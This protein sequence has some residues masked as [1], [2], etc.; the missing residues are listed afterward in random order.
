MI[1]YDD[2]VAALSQWRAR[3]GLPV[4]TMGGAGAAPAA[5]S[6]GSGPHAQ[7]G[8]GPMAKPGSGPTRGAPPMAP[9]RA[10]APSMPPPLQANTVDDAMDVDDA[11]M[12]EEQYD[13]EGS[14]F[15]MGF[16]N[17]AD[18]GESTS[19]GQAPERPT[20]ADMGG[21]GRDDW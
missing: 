3:Q 13:N 5:P 6:P 18:D 19:I 17:Q 14:D 20:E 1:P 16:G 9:P 11:A 8:S 2:L 4:S 21:N 10:K 15:A 7:P 12:L